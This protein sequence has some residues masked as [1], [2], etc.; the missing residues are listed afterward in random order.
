MLIEYF[1]EHGLLFKWGL[2]ELKSENAVSKY[3]LNLKYSIQSLHI[4]ID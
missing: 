3:I 1:K 2:L 4:F